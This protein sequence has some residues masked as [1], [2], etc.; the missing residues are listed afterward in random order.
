MINKLSQQLGRSISLSDVE[1]ECVS[2]GLSII[3]FH[4]LG[5]L[6]AAMIGMLFDVALELFIV[7]FLYI[8]L[9]VCAGG[10]HARKPEYCLVY[11]SIMLC[12][13]CIGI[14]Y[15]PWDYGMVTH[16]LFIILILVVRVIVDSKSIIYG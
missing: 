14:K 6:L 16:S 11:S 13:L 5:F 8:P 15:V 2:L 4:L 3:A 1:V 10:F 9:R 12:L 7:I